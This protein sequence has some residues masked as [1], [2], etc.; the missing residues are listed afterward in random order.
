MFWCKIF[1]ISMIFPITS[2][3]LTLDKQI[4]SAWNTELLLIWQIFIFSW[5]GVPVK[6]AKKNIEF[7]E[8]I[9][10]F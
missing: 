10:F 7:K 6:M 4:D 9:L 2:S 3:T 8:G 1:L 5:E